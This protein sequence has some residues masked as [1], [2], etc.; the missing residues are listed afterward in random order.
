M[1]CIKNLAKQASKMQMTQTLNGTLGNHTHTCT[2]IYTHKN[3]HPSSSV[4]QWD[5]KT[6]C[7]T[8]DIFLHHPDSGFNNYN[9]IQMW[10]FFMT[11]PPQY[12]SSIL[13]I[14]FCIQF[15][16]IQYHSLLN[17]LFLLLAHTILSASFPLLNIEPCPQ[18]L[19]YSHACLT[20][21]I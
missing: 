17:Q 19:I 7:Y 15:T 11:R 16:F 1:V 3:N 14:H 9:N 21:F 5:Y 2:Y 6:P 10:Y 12:T 13:G 8:K 18:G 4:I 20:V